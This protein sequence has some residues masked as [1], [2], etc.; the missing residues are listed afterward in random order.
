M[1]KHFAK[2][3]TMKKS[4]LVSI[5]STTG[6]IVLAAIGIVI[7]ILHQMGAAGRLSTWDASNGFMLIIAY[8]CFFGPM[9]I[10]L[11]WKLLCSGSHKSDDLYAQEVRSARPQRVRDTS[12]EELLEA[13][14]D[15][16]VKAKSEKQAQEFIDEILATHQ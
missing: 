8:G 1:K 13:F 7:T 3:L 15:I 16:L 11:G 10:V 5:V 4:T 6:A 12:M 9:V 2:K 14:P